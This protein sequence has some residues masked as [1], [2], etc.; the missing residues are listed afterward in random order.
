MT[1]PTG[2]ATT[3]FPVV[4][5]GASAGGLEA[6]EEFFR[7][8]PAD[9]GMAFIVVMHQSA[10][11][12]SLLAE[13][14]D[15]CTPMDVTQIRDGSTAQPNCVYVVPPGMNLD[16]L[17][18]KFHLTRMTPKQATSLPIDY[19][20][21]S[22]A[23]D[24]RESAVAIVFS[25]TGTDGTVGLSSIKNAAGM[26]MVQSI[27]SAK[28]T[29]MPQNAIQAGWADYIL[30]PHEMPAQLIAYARGPFLT[31]PRLVNQPAPGTRESLPE[32]LLLLRRRCGHDFSGY[33]HSTICRRVE[34]RMNVHQITDPKQYL[35]FL[36][37]HAPEA[38]S[39]FTELLIGVTSFFRDPWAFDALAE[40]AIL[41]LLQGK[42]VNAKF[43]VW[44]PGCSTGEEAY[45]LAILLDECLEKLQIKL[46][47]QIFATDLD[48]DAIEIARRGCFSDAIVNDVPPARLSRY[49]VKHGSG[50]RI[51][52][53]LREWLVFAP[54]NVIHD[55]PFTKLDLVSC[56][57]LLIYLNPELQQKL[58]VLFHYAL[59]PKGCLFL[60]TSETIGEFTDLFAILHQKAKVY[61]RKEGST[62][63]E[64]KVEF[65]VSV[66]SK[67]PKDGPMPADR[68]Q[69]SNV[70]K[71]NAI[72]EM[73]LAQ[74]V[75]PTVLVDEK[76]E[77]LHV[78]GRTGKF[79]EL[80]EGDPSRNIL[81]M[82][83]QGL[84]L[85]LSAAL[86][87]AALRDGPVVH[88]GVQSKQMVT[89]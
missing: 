60:G 28:F 37:E 62:R 67:K 56:R 46:E 68:I 12:V 35:R 13:L 51:R 79:L 82:A 88:S 71:D 70:P 6:L 78:H 77:I 49:F 84:E 89:R 69:P 19:F 85:E 2:I 24:R 3:T 66:V 61:R 10:K 16:L 21:R 15:K 33:K 30:A 18:G 4:G 45:S 58:L 5:L 52:Q 81:A 80:A 23:E 47:I 34:R 42:S 64:R 14:L 26:V 29:G 75:P 27:E 8:M 63:S 25:G 83:R 38:E 39:L 73:L 41:R 32:I 43:R 53:D 17:N 76:G 54:Q 65:P 31:A 40:T 55:P 7:H 20:F 22:L 44:V 87:K 57:N 9:A 11:H 59:A 36:S 50:F 48:R 72:A 74:F 86:R 1:R